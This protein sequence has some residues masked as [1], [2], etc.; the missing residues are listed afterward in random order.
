MF[1]T[2][3]IFFIIIIA[4]FAYGV[5][6]ISYKPDVIST[7]EIIAK[8]SSIEGKVLCRHFLQSEWFTLKKDDEIYN[9]DVVKTSEGAAVNLKFIKNENDISLSENTSAEIKTSAVKVNS[10]SIENNS[11][12]DN[13]FAISIGDV[14]VVLK[15][16]EGKNKK[17]K[18]EHSL[19]DLVSTRLNKLEKLAS[20]E[21]FNKLQDEFTKVKKND[22]NEELEQFWRKLNQMIS[23]LQLNKQ[24]VKISKSKDGK[25]KAQVSEGKVSL[26]IEGTVGSVEVKEGTGL[27]LNKDSGE[28]ERVKLLDAPKIYYPIDNKVVYNTQSIRVVWSELD[29]ATS[30]NVL[31]YEKGNEPVAGSKD[32]EGVSISSNTHTFQNLIYGK[33]YSL[34]ISALDKHDFK[35]KLADLNFE[36]QEDRVPPKL[37]IKDIT[38]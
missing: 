37:D 13:P 21:G 9:K 4:I 28:V 16:R 29:N 5:Y 22:S 20:K 33:K 8:V 19:L 2:Q 24:K 10:G 31:V 25:I 35:G 23:K 14:Q 38:F 12:G 3:N 11:Q 34:S 15:V 26:N 32:S 36:L 7:Q 30:Y 18:A 1:K 17:L 6:L 27:I